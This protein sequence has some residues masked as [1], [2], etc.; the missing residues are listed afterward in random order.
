MIYYIIS[1]GYLRFVLYNL[2]HR[3]SNGYNNHNHSNSNRVCVCVRI[4][5]KQTN[6]HAFVIKTFEIHLVVWENKV[7]SQ[8]IIIEYT[9]T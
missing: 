1:Y 2:T 8:C 3:T 7:A 5:I 4:P 9:Y 6:D